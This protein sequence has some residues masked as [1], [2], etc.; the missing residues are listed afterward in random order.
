MLATAP[1][2]NTHRSTL[3]IRADRVPK[4]KRMRG[5]VSTNFTD[6][7]G[8]RIN[9]QELQSSRPDRGEGHKCAGRG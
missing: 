7:G 4:K 6:D 9:A 2:G 1:P 5:G 3:S 8:V